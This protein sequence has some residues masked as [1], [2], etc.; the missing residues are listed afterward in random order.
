MG[1][2]SNTVTRRVALGSVLGGLASL[3]GALSYIRSRN[4]P[5]VTRAKR[6]S[7]LSTVQIK[8]AI[9]SGTVKT[10]LKADEIKDALDVLVRERSMWARLNSLVGRMSVAVEVN[11]VKRESFT[12]AG[13]VSLSR[14]Q[15]NA[16]SKLRWED[17]SML[18]SDPDDRWEFKTDGKGEHRRFIAKDEKLA[19]GIDTEALASLPSILLTPRMAILSI[20]NKLDLYEI[21]VFFPPWR[22]K[23]ASGVPNSY[24]YIA[25]IPGRSR[26]EMSFENGHFSAW[27]AMGEN[28][29]L[30][31]TTYARETVESNGFWFPTKLRVNVNDENSS[32][33]WQIALGELAVTQSNA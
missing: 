9:T 31:S 8:R 1:V 21:M 3:A 2:M 5:M 28:N 24:T 19:A 23:D 16:S 4:R 30:Y 32:E 29:K 17:Y 13:N 20:F 12:L 33:K 6:D 10:D 7:G 27:R 22:N 25:N 26:D 11:D 15:A 18:F 14:L